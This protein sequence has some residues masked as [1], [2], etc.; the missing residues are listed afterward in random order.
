[1]EKQ[2]S[3]NKNNGYKLASQDGLEN[4]S[5]TAKKNVYHLHT[6]LENM[7]IYIDFEHYNSQWRS[8]GYCHPGPKY[9]GFK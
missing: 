8:R 6:H 5:F 2:E 1:M 7:E 9:N 3:S 4:K